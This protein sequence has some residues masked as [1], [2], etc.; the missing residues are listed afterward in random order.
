V[1]LHEYGDLGLGDSPLDHAEDELD[2]VV[3]GC[4]E[5]PPVETQER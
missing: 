1:V 4:L 2:Q 3:V 5:P